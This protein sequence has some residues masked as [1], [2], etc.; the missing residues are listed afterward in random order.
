[1]DNVPLIFL[2]MV[3]TADAPTLFTVCPCVPIS[4]CTVV[5]FI[6]CASTCPVVPAWAAHTATAILCNQD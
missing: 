1:M 6:V 4:A 2:K 3:K 5:H